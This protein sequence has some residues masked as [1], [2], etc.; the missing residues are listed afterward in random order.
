MA[1]EIVILT[2]AG[3]SA[4]SGLGTFRDVGG[5][6]SQY[7]LEDVA[8]PQGYARDPDLVLG[9]YNARR[10]NARMAAPNAAH[11]A[12]ARLQREWP[13][14]VTLVTQNIDDLHERGGSPEVV[15]MHGEIMRA[16][17]ASCGHRWGWTGAM[18]RE[19][20]CPACG[21]GALV[22]P[23][24]VWFGEMPYH[25][26]LIGERLERAGLFVAIGTSGAVYPAAG[27]VAEAAGA[28]VP[29]IEINLERSEVAGMF[30]RHI[31][32]PASETVPLWVE[33][34]LSG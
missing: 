4:E 20:T 23:D 34:M 21:R 2:G 27:F 9:F 8:T 6:W 5:L 33:G 16:L 32:G 11:R 19:D 14:A 31:L 1:D 17:C 25:L 28:G 3:I 12:I 26:D 22:R 10:E 13:G 29:T 15:H 24:V 30:D 18:S 7:D